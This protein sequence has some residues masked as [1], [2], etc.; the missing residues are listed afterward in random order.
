MISGLLS[1]KSTSRP[2]RALRVL[3]GFVV[4]I[5]GGVLA[6]P[7]VPGPGIPI[8]LLGLWVL[9]D[10]FVWARR[11]LDWVKRK[12]ASVL[13]ADSEKR[14]R[15]WKWLTACLNKSEGNGRL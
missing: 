8:I 14:G 7:G 12:I 11:A 9:S 10:H 6:L 15:G 13:P 1:A 5:V 4:L 3:V 2:V